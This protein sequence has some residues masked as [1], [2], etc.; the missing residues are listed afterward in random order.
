MDENIGFYQKRIAVLDLMIAILFSA[1]RSLSVPLIFPDLGLAYPLIVRLDSSP[2][3][4][5]L[6]TFHVG[7]RN[8]AGSVKLA[9]ELLAPSPLGS[10][11]A[12]RCLPTYA[13]CMMS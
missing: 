10:A 3:A 2:S 5:M 6:S 8:G 11:V 4:L 13:V 7:L 12:E 1:S 9:H